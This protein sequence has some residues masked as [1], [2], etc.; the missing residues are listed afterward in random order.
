MPFTLRPLKTVEDALRHFIQ[1]LDLDMV[2]LLLESLPEEDPGDHDSLLQDLD[3]V[4]A[5]FK[6]LGDE[7][8]NV[9]QGKCASCNPKS[10]GFM[11]VGNKSKAYMFLLFYR[12]GSGILSIFE[13]DEFKTPVAISNSKKRVYLNQYKFRRLTLGEIDEDHVPF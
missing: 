4:F 1:V 7:E 9:I 5:Y 2:K 8:L 12:E 13:C 10:S 11:F 6:S 3:R